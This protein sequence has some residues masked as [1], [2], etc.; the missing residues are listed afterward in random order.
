MCEVEFFWEVVLRKVL[1]M[2]YVLSM[3]RAHVIR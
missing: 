1:N 3:P 2:F